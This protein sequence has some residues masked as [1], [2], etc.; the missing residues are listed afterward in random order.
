MD[1]NTQHFV[2]V[3]RLTSI[4]YVI[5]GWC[6]KSAPPVRFDRHSTFTYWQQR[7]KSRT[8][9]KLR[10]TP[11]NNNWISFSE[12]LK[13]A[14]T[15]SMP[16]ILPVLSQPTHPQKTCSYCILL[17]LWTTWNLGHYV[18]VSK[19]GQITY[20]STRW[21][22]TIFKGLIK[23]GTNET[24]LGT[25]CCTPNLIP[26]VVHPSHISMCSPWTPNQGCM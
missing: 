2:R 13:L 10:V 4:A 3:D 8:V 16:I 14:M 24:L 9:N 20:A 19:S 17:V 11:S 21:L 25:Y 22:R 6:D 26:Q 5:W 18:T 23:L 1:S 15:F 12:F 7:R